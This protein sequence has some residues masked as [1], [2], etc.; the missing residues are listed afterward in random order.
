MSLNLGELMIRVSADLSNFRKEFASAQQTI[1]ASGAMMQRAGTDLEKSMAG[2]SKSTSG[3][4]IPTTMLL[5]QQLD[6][7]AKTGK[8]AGQAMADASAQIAP[9][10]AKIGGQLDK[11]GK[12][13]NDMTGQVDKAQQQ[14]QLLFGGVVLTGAFTVPFVSAMKGALNSTISFEEAFSGV[15]KTVDGS[16]AEFAQLEKRFR[17]M[18]QVVPVAANEFARIGEIAGQLGI[19]GVDNITKFVEVIAKLGVATDMT[20]DAAA[21]QLA[22]FANIMQMPIS[23]VDQLG[24]SLVHLGNNLA[25][26][27][28]EIAEFALRIAGAGKT[29]GL[30]EHQ[31]LSFGGALASVGIN[32]EA[33]GTAVSRVFISLAEAVSKGG[34]QLDLFAKIANVSAG[35]FAR[36]FREDAAA[37]TTAFV[38][39][40]GRVQKSGGDLF[41]VL[42]QLGLEEVRVRDALLRLAGS[43]DTLRKSLDLGRVGWEQN[44]A[45]NEEAA[46]KYGTTASQIQLLR[47][48]WDE[49]LRQLG[50]TAVPLLTSVVA[51]LRDMMKAFNDLSPL[52]KGVIVGLSGLLAL[53]GPLSVALYSV[54]IAV[55][56]LRTL[57]AFMAAS[58]LPGF[59]AAVAAMLTNPITIGILA[60]AGLIA[61]LEIM[62]RAV[63]N[64]KSEKR[65]Q[66]DL[67]YLLEQRAK[68][69]RELA[70]LQEREAPAR[71]L[72]ETEEKLRGVNGAMQRLLNTM[73]GE[74][75]M[76]L[77]DPEAAAEAITAQ[78]RLADAAQQAAQDMEHGAQ[79][80]ASSTELSASK[81][82]TLTH[83]LQ[84]LTAEWDIYKAQAGDVST[85]TVAL[86]R[87]ADNLQARLG[88][89]NEKVAL[90]GSA[91]AEAVAKGGP[92]SES[93][94]DLATQLDSASKAGA[95]LQG[96]LNNIA[97]AQQRANDPMKATAVAL[98]INDEKLRRL[99][100][101]WEL[102]KTRAGDAA[103]SAEGL[104]RQK[105]S[106]TARLDLAGDSV[107]KLTTMYERS[108]QQT[109]EFS[110]ESL[111]LA[112]QLDGARL[113]AAQYEAGV[114][115]VN[116]ALHE[117]SAPVLKVK[118]DLSKANAEV[119]KGKAAVEDYG[120]Q[121]DKAKESLAG[122]TKAIDTLKD[123]NRT[124]E[125]SIKDALGA[126]EGHIR[127]VGEQIKALQTDNRTAEQSMT[128]AFRVMESHASDLRTEIEA[129][130]RAML[131]LT[132][133][134]LT[135]DSAFDDKLF[136]LQ[137]QEAL[138]RL[139]INALKQQGVD[140][141]D[142][143]LVALE[144][145]LDE[146]GLQRE[147]V[148]LERQIAVDPL[149]RELKKLTDDTKELS[150]D[151]ART[152]ILAYQQKIVD[153]TK[154]HTDMT[155]EIG[156]LRGEV[157]GLVPSLSNAKMTF[158]AAKAAVDLHKSAITANNAE[159]AALTLKQ[160]EMEAAL[161]ATKLTLVALM[162][163][164]ADVKLGFD[165]AKLQVDAHRI[166]L[167]ENA[168]AMAALLLKQA[169]QEQKVTDLTTKLTTAR[170]EL[171]K[172]TEKADTASTAL[173]TLRTAALAAASALALQAATGVPAPSAPAPGAVPA[174]TPAPSPATAS[175][176][177]ATPA[178]TPAAT[179]TP[180]TGTAADPVPGFNL[181][182]IRWL[183]NLITLPDGPLVPPL[184]PLFGGKPVPFAKGGIVTGPTLS[185]LGE[186]G[187]EAVIPLGRLGALLSSLG[188][189]M[190]ASMNGMGAP[191]ADSVF[192]SAASKGGNV[193]FVITGN[194]ILGDDSRVAREIA[195]AVEPYIL[196]RR[197][198]LEV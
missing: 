174:G 68:L 132:N 75:K 169:E 42:E 175:A 138:V 92:F 179:T 136:Q 158:D 28:S 26:T 73:T 156:R 88:V 34:D 195:R 23:K 111:K 198:Q 142:A 122:T 90:L 36:L 181:D 135:G 118:E 170:A 16:E 67:N 40:L 171:E 70:D 184:P 110:D 160:A 178:N 176:A 168:T 141:A 113:T 81:L 106:L 56:G 58:A 183:F 27:E 35:E 187:P 3:I 48:T 29:I 59:G 78:K 72:R 115:D 196:R 147:Q 98:T 116:L 39:G 37:A 18:S 107:A 33:G 45:L 65:Q 8:K 54:S 9:A 66:E 50:Q 150:F 64:Q 108:V 55:Q 83:R 188:A 82:T 112:Q 2:Y 119:V 133:V 194:T 1:A 57:F 157:V 11:I 30:S 130:R 114:R 49:L 14:L 129:T 197:V 172:W 121:L 173:D 105:A 4:L 97:K 126:M 128:D 163:S 131:D 189:R 193:T 137:Q 125:Q 145:R 93:A 80:T 12:K 7:V 153:L 102:F 5:E 186:A 91:Y 154:E 46:K 6:K 76:P 17:D 61:A 19:R 167:Q 177:G 13:T 51:T 124:A 120:K 143:S 25:A 74:T 63:Q 100:S 162:P 96:E 87:H 21:T 31:V 89:V 84:R 117:F 86:A 95:E 152:Q 134:R 180:L 166:K 182:G 24:A 53:L 38:E 20:T 60:V 15:R 10:A 151:E 159:I 71:F 62:S 146:I 85:N 148:T 103:N 104:N 140:K 185:L 190:A 165:E 94:M 69:Q 161:D 164:L 22:R 41:G 99:N 52:T 127:A 139:G 43:G 47:G 155:K 32:A 192:G 191:A 149:R 101:E 44:I 123:A 79:R 77:L 109:G 144:N